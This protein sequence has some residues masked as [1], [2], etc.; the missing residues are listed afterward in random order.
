MEHTESVFPHAHY[1]PTF[2]FSFAAAGWLQTYH[3]GVAKAIQEFGFDGPS[4]RFCGSSAGS[5]AAAALV[6]KVDFDALREYAVACVTDCHSSF[7]NAFRIREYVLVG[8]ERFA[9]QR[10]RNDESLR[11]S[12]NRQLE[13][14]VSVLPW[15][16]KR[17]IHQFPEAEDLEEALVASCCLVPLA[18]LPLKL[19]HTGE[20][21]C[22][23]G[24]TAFQPR[25][26][27]KHVIT[28]SAMYFSNAEIHPTNFTPSWWGLYPPSEMKYREIFDEGYN[29]AIRYFVKNN[30]TNENA[31][32]K[33]KHVPKRARETKWDIIGD[34]LTGVVFTCFIR[35]WAL[36][37]I[38]AEMVI[39]AVVLLVIAL[40]QLTRSR[41]WENCYHSVRNL[42]S[43]RILLHFI[44][45][46][47]IPINLPRLEKH[48]VVYRILKPLIYE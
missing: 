48:S 5:L 25:N 13:V 35:P 14:Y 44:L 32:T 31:L 42:V 8:I 45:G 6:T 11:E 2:T 1:Q 37:F 19:R 7:L 41:S 34:V 20:Y 47:K 21:V 27:Q 46:K 3:F 16:R 9:V 39:S 43:F 10:F 15:C 17:V 18:G 28:V 33:L 29:D 23:G 12:L 40:V 30:L 36:V 4:V 26:G 38:Y 24:L 22:D